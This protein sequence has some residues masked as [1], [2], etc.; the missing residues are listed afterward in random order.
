MPFPS[1]LPRFGDADLVQRLVHLGNHV[2]TVQDVERLRGFL[3]DHVQV[4]L[5]HVA[6]R[7]SR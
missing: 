3:A 5:P 1:H 4:G 2:E 7:G 6:G